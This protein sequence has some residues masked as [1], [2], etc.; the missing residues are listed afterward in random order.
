MAHRPMARTALRTKSTT[1]RPVEFQETKID[2]SAK[3]KTQLSTP[4]LL[5]QSQGLARYQQLGR[6]QHV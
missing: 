3:I 6:S 4:L 1:T 2:L 5:S